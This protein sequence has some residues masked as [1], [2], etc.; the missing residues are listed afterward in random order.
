MTVTGE[1][2]SSDI[3]SSYLKEA[4]RANQ[5]SV[6]RA[7]SKKHVLAV[8]DNASMRVLFYE[9]LSMLDY[10]VVTAGNGAEAF[11]HFIQNNFDLVITDCK[12]PGMDGWQLAEL[13]KSVSDQTPIIMVTGQDQDKVMD[14]LQG[15]NIDYLMLKP[16]DLDDFY[17]TVR[18]SLN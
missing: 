6:L 1:P 8:D 3:K 14:N 12:M 9:A 15:G 18:A 17:N 7:N 10:D 4:E 5:K 13:I 16:L 2:V 11:K